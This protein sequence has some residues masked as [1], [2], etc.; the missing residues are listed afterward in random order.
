M[1]AKQQRQYQKR[2][3]YKEDLK[4]LNDAVYVHNNAQNFP[5]KV[6][7]ENDDIIITVAGNIK[8]NESE[9]FYQEVIPQEVRTNYESGVYQQQYE[10]LKT[11]LGIFAPPAAA[12][13]LGIKIGADDTILEAPTTLPTSSSKE[14]YD[15]RQPNALLRYESEG[16]QYI[17]TYEDPMI[18]YRALRGNEVKEHPANKEKRPDLPAMWYKMT[19]VEDPREW[20]AFTYDKATGVFN[21]YLN[22]HNK[23]VN[24]SKRRFR[25]A[26][27]IET[28]Q[29]GLSDIGASDG[30]YERNSEGMYRDGHRAIDH[31]ITDGMFN[32]MHYVRKN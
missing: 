21:M 10:Q 25:D 28:V 16:S 9:Q 4:K 2:E 26:N 32:F 18:T 7:F 23:I 31:Y 30:V 8:N 12:K 5:A 22:D 14:I 13:E 19:D 11:E 6:V 27:H 15:L 3:K 17:L 1:A 20:T 29:T 24:Y